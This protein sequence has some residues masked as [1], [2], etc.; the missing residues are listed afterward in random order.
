[1]ELGPSLKQMMPLSNYEYGT[2]LSC[3]CLC[4]TE[5]GIAQPGTLPATKG[6]MPSGSWV[7]YSLVISMAKKRRWI[8]VWPNGSIYYK[9]SFEHGRPSGDFYTSETGKLMSKINHPMITTAI[10]YG[11]NG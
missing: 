3:L 9:G 4:S 10:H 7:D 8:R 1:M 5:L 6:S 2:F 11:P